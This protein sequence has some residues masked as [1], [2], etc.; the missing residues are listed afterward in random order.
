MITY[1]MYD[2]FKLNRLNNKKLINGSIYNH[3]H[4]QE[5]VVNEISTGKEYEFYHPRAA[6]IEFQVKVKQ[7]AN[8]I[9]GVK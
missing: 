5:S 4:L 1:P 7:F 3:V 6:E 2:V 9:N 8:K